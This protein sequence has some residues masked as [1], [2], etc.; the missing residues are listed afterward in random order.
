MVEE[1]TFGFRGNFHTLTTEKISKVGGIL[2]GDFLKAVSKPGDVVSLDNLLKST[3]EFQ[4]A[5]GAYE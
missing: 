3:T 5:M 4:A 2:A 1:Y